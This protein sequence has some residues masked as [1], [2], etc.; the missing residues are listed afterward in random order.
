MAISIFLPPGGNFS[1]TSMAFLLPH[2]NILFNLAAA[3]HKDILFG[4]M[5]FSTSVCMTAMF[6]HFVVCLLAMF[7]P[8]QAEWP[9]L[10]FN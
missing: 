1:S 2:G 4:L 5:A 3:P 6:L 10:L 7:K 8:L 9:L